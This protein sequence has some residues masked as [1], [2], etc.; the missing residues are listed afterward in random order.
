M[1]PTE[2]LVI[3]AVL[4][5]GTPRFYWDASASGITKLPPPTSTDS[6]RGRDLPSVRSESLHTSGVGQA[7]A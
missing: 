2:G 1:A 4:A 5:E 3:P 6:G 7:S